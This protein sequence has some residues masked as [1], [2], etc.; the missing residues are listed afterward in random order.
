MKTYR[1]T[2]Q[3]R[4]NMSVVSYRDSLT[5]K[6]PQKSLTKGGKRSVGRNNK[7]RITV[8]HKGGGHKR[9]FR[10][11][12]FRFDKKNIP[13]KIETIE[14]DPNRSGFIALVCYADG[15]RRYILSPR[16]M[17]VGDKFMV[18]DK[19][20]E[21]KIGNRMP[22][23][24]IP[25]GTF[26]YNIEVKP[27]NGGKLARSAGNFA[28]LVA[29]DGGYAQLKMPSSETRKVPDKCFAS[30]G[31][32]SNSKHRLTKV[33]KAGRSRWM[34]RRPTVRGSAMNAVDHPMGGGEG[35][36]GRGNRRQKTLWGKHAGKGQKTRK[37]KKY[38]NYLIV[39]RRKV[40]KKRGK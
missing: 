17:K 7:G 33:G 9:K 31:E 34:G 20:T 15:E 25:V 26:V 32:V 27:G 23:S 24:K 35:R 16:K 22:L 6:G 18:S 8:R 2:T 14:Y 4:R 37:P 1:P 3:S 28:E 38:S 5:A 13:A 36:S 40:G 19:K 30:I 11:I 21:V 12:D 29:V 10:D 39:S